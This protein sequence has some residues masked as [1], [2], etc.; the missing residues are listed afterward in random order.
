MFIKGKSQIL[1]FFKIEKRKFYI[2][3]Q[4]LN[5]TDLEVLNKLKM[6]LF[7]IV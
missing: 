1:K 7:K 5:T 2:L 4:D 6:Y 3:Y